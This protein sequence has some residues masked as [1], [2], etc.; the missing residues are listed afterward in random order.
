MDRLSEPFEEQQDMLPV[1]MRGE[2]LRQNSLKN[3]RVE[4]G[5]EV[6]VEAKENR[7]VE[8]RKVPG[9]VEAREEERP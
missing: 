6:G 2:K 4:A 7:K 8:E 9:L 3:L 5:V 1:R